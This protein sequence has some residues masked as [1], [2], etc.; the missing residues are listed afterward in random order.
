[1]PRG[2]AWLTHQFAGRAGAAI[3]RDAVDLHVLELQRLHEGAAHV[4]AKDAGE[5]GLPVGMPL[6][7]AIGEGATRLAA[8]DYSEAQTRKRWQ[9][10][11]LP[12]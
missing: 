8:A 5:F 4:V 2:D 10:P 7:D 3:A 6:H 1:M 12:R 11:P 9:K